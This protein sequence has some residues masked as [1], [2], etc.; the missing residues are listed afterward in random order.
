MQSNS[1]YLNIVHR[2]GRKVYMISS[3]NTFLTSSTATIY[4]S[5]WQWEIENQAFLR[6]RFS[7]ISKYTTTPTC[8]RDLKQRNCRL[9]MV[10]QRKQV[11]RKGWDRICL[12]KNSQKMQKSSVQVYHRSFQYQLNWMR[13]FHSNYMVTTGIWR[14]DV[15][16]LLYLCFFEVSDDVGSNMLQYIAEEHIKDGKWMGKTQM[17]CNHV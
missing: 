10:Q 6:S 9:Q 1:Y 17:R 4:F 13:H 3:K 12:K 15:E 14:S 16:I 7:F 8:T 2:N 5:A 11:S